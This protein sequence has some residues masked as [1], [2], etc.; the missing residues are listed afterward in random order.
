MKYIISENKMLDL[1]DKFLNLSYDSKTKEFYSGDIDDVI[2]YKSGNGFTYSTYRKEDILHSFFGK[3]TNEILLS[4]L[5][6]K[7][8]ELNIRMIHT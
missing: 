3:K 7:F 8:P 5:N 6:K 1:M 2:G 4:Y